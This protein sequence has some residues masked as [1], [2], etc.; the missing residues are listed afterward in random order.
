MIHNVLNRALTLIPRVKFE[1]RKFLGVETNQFGQSVQSFGPW[2]EV[3]GMESPGMVSAFGGKNMEEV[4]YKALGL[5]PSKRTITVW[6]SG[7]DIGATV[8]ENG[9]DQIRFEGE[10]FNILNTENWLGYN[11]WKRCYCQEVVPSVG[12]GGAS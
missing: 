3:Y 1:Y 12:N 6:L 4:E 8:G 5:D 7:V 10:T 2:T 11:G 9:G